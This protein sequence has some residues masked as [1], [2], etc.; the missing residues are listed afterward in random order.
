MKNV[1]KFST[2]NASH[3]LILWDNVQH[4]A[5]FKTNQPYFV[6]GLLVSL[7]EHGISKVSINFKE[8]E[9]K[10]NMVLVIFS[11]SILEIV[12]L[13]ETR[14]VKAFFVPPNMLVDQ[15]MFA[16]YEMFV[17]LTKFPL[18]QI[19]A[20]KMQELIRFYD[21]VLDQ[22]N[23]V[24]EY[25]HIEYD[26][27]LINVLSV[28]LKSIYKELNFFELNVVK[29]NNEIIVDNFYKLLFDNYKEERNVAFYAEKL[30]LS[31]KHLSFIVKQVL[32]KP[33]Y[34]WI[35]RALINNIKFRLR[36]TNMTVKEL[37]DE[38]NFTTPSVLVRFFKKNTGI[39]PIQYR[40]QK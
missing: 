10:E 21:F 24:D 12:E 3:R 25:Y 32:G 16:N 17:Y 36:T 13:D 8:Y 4:P 6:D 37:A 19:S 38:F 11:Q 9:T 29:S 7:I 1:D 22:Y 28:K 27:H 14:R 34:Y 39:T 30:C 31:P 40:E 5:I 18:F 23:S 35:T 15:E 2:P 26:K 20:E 33:I